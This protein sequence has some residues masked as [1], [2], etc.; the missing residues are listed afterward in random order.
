MAAH[1]KESETVVC[2]PT[3]TIPPPIYANSPGRAAPP[4][5]FGI[6]HNIV[7]DLCSKGTLTGGCWSKKSENTTTI[8]LVEA[9]KMQYSLA[10]QS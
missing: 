9:T 4:P 10:E 2:N 5:M 8:I 7:A 1:K 3:T 6:V